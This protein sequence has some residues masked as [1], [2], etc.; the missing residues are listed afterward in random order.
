MTRTTSLGQKNV[1]VKKSVSSALKDSKGGNLWWVYPL[2]LPQT[3]T[4]RQL[5]RASSGLQWVTGSNL[6]RAFFPTHQ[7]AI[8][9][10]GPYTVL[11]RESPQLCPQL[12]SS[13]W[14]ATGRCC[15]IKRGGSQK[16]QRK[17]ERSLSESLQEHTSAILAIAIRLTSLD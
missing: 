8:P 15:W 11:M 14:L 9:T 10:R 16:H 12:P 5:T 4:D 7:A 1:L 3:T 2:L 6:I 17:H 13:G